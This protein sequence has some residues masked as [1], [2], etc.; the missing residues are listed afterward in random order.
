MRGDTQTRRRDKLVTIRCN[1]A[2]HETILRGL[3][4]GPGMSHRARELLLRSARARIASQGRND[5]QRDG[6]R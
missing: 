5:A 1:A 3:G 6:N 2:E 4:G